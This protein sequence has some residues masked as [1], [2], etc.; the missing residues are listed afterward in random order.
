M[1][2]PH[3]RQID[4]VVFDVGRVIVRWDMRI[5]FAKLIEDPQELDWFC[6]NVVTEAWHG[7][8][9]AGRPIGEMTAERIATFPEYRAAIEAYRDRWLDTIPGVVPGVPELIEQL[10]ARDVPLFAI[11]NFGTDFW[12]QFRPAQPVLD[13]FRDIVVSGHERL[14]KPGSA[15]FRLAAA[16]FGHAP[17]R[18]LFIDDSLPNVEAAARLGWHAH[19]FTDAVTL[20]A[21]LTRH[22]LL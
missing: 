8:H 3:S 21:D 2:D 4:A 6:T 11:T 17:E 16:R 9:D 20:E 7:Q 5:L 10:A 18:M 14:V 15:I 1:F 13:H 22:G 19:H 12:A